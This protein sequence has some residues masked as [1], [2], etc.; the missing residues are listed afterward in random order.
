M[1]FFSRVFTSAL[2]ALAAIA[3]VSGQSTNLALATAGGI[4]TQA[5]DYEFDEGRHNRT[6]SK[7]IDGFTSGVIDNMFV[8]CIEEDVWWEVLLEAN[9][10]IDKIVIFNRGSYFYRL[11]DTKVQIF[12]ETGNVSEIDL[13]VGKV[14]NQNKLL[15]TSILNWASLKLLASV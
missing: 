14:W 5:C 2:L 3:P 7:G 8:T 4:A 6:A 1:R 10:A 11:Q 12:D 9:V 13:I 15:W